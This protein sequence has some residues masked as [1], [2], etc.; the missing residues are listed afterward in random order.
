MKNIIFALAV[1]LT[2]NMTAQE[3]EDHHQDERRKEMRHKRAQKHLKDLTPEQIATLRT[4]KLTLALD[5]S[6]SQQRSVLELYTKVAKTRKEK[7]EARKANKDKNK[8]LTSEEKYAMM[9]AKLDAQIAHKKSMKEILSASQY[10]KWE[11]IMARK[12]KKKRRGKKKH[13][14]N[15]K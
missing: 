5:L 11:K 12:G 10:E 1:L 8:K 6:A 13:R 15:K 3:S 4:K 7:M 9:N 2:L 14:E